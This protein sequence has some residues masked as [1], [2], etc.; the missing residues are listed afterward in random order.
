VRAAK[1]RYYEDRNFTARVLPAP[2][3][4]AAPYADRPP[5]RDNDWTSLALPPAPPV[6]ASCVAKEQAT[7]E[8]IRERGPNGR[9]DVPDPAQLPL[10][11]DE[12]TEDADEA[13]R[14]ARRHV[15]GIA[16]NDGRHPSQGIPL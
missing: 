2:D 7:V 10:L 6:A 3:L 15:L 5:A 16:R 11:A 1:L 12:Q 8:A 13:D 9:L 4:G 14:M